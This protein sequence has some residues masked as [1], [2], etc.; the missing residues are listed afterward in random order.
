M[1]IMI[2]MTT[3]SCGV[4]REDDVDDDDGGFYA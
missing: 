3:V 4:C 2:M 1:M